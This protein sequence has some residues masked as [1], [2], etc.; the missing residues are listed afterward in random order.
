MQ[1]STQYHRFDRTTSLIT[2]NL[3]GGGLGAIPA[4][5]LCLGHILY[6]GHLTIIDD[7]G[8]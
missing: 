8:H 3:V 6:N 1:P 7:S 5:A 4:L 2:A